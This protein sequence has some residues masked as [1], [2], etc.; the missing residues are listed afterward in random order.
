MG[1]RERKKDTLSQLW[2]GK[3]EREKVKEEEGTGDEWDSHL[4]I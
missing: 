3:E 1:E 2:R 4:F